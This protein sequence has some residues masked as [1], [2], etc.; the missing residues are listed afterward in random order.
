MRIS[1]MCAQ[2]LGET[3]MW[4]S[5]WISSFKWSANVRVLFRGLD[6]LQRRCSQDP[7]PTAIVVSSALGAA[8]WVL[9]VAAWLLS[10]GGGGVCL[11]V[12]LVRRARNRELRNTSGVGA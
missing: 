3:A 12:Y 1:A 7:T 10:F 11:G 5:T 6:D 8:G 9:V 2:V 4:F